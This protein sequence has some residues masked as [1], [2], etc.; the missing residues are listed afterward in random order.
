[1]LGNELNTSD[2]CICGHSKHKS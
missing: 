1:M 2:I